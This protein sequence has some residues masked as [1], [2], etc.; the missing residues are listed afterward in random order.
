[1]TRPDVEPA[2]TP[3]GDPRTPILE[4]TNLTKYFPIKSAG[5]LRRSIGSVQAVDGVSFQVERGSALGLVGESGLRQVDDRPADHPALRPDVGVDEVRRSRDRHPV[6]QADAAAAQRDPDDLPGPVQL[7]EPAAHGR[8]HRRHAAA[9]AQDGAGEQGPGPGPGAPRGR[10][11]QPRAL[12]P[13][14][15]RVL[16]RPAPAHRH[17]AGPGPAAQAAGGRRAGLRARR[18]HPGAGRQPAAGRAAGVR[19]RVPVHRARPRRGP[20]LLPGDRGDVPR[21]DRRDRATARP[22]TAPR[23]TP[24]RRRCCRRCPT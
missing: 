22:S 5:L 11:P 3:A 7:A 10:R 18:V 21:Q 12:Q 23:T 14:P 16:R 2:A 6:E 19:H 9:G 1:M 24:T 8:H 13:L 4:V 15:Q 20:A 17:R